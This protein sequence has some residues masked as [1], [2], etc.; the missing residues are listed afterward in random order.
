LAEAG[1]TVV[2]AEKNGGDTTVFALAKAGLATAGGAGFVT[3]GLINPDLNG[4]GFF[5]YMCS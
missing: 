1:D 4:G 3:D 2:L 5:T